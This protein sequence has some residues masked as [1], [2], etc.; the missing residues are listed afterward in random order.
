MNV[1]QEILNAF[2]RGKAFG[3]A[4]GMKSMSAEIEALKEALRMKVIL[5]EHAQQA[6]KEVKELLK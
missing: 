6:M 2:E 3:F 5:N 4:E 1:E